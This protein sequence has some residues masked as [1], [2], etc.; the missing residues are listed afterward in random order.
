MR[1][2]GGGGRQGAQEKKEKEG[3]RESDWD[4]DREGG[5]DGG[6]GGDREGTGGGGGSGARGDRERG[7]GVEREG[8]M[9]GWR[10]RESGIEVWM[11][12]E[13]SKLE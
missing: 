6:G 3:W 4:G 7:V 2:R 10:E 13:D 1:Q 11:K 8:W 5:G 12:I 9:A